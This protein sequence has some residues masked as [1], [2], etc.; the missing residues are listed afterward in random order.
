MSKE[1]VHQFELDLGS[2]QEY[3]DLGL[4]EDGLVEQ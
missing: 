3:R 4:L 2:Y 1:H